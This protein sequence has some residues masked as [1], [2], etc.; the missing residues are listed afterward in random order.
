[1]DKAV[2]YSPIPCQ[3]ATITAFPPIPGKL[4]VLAHLAPS[5]IA[6]PAKMENGLNQYG[7]VV[8]ATEKTSSC[9]AL[10]INPLVM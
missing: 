5:A 9:I 10:S 1:M 3:A 8:L 4:A 7:S 2:G 6:D